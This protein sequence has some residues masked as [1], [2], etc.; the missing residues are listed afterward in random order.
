MTPR[1]PPRKGT[2]Y[3]V[4]PP[5]SDSLRMWAMTITGITLLVVGLI[6]LIDVTFDVFTRNTNRPFE[7]V[8]F[9]FTAGVAFMWFGTGRKFGHHDVDVSY[10]TTKGDDSGE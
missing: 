6:L 1:R 3:Y 9:L 4:I 10:K 5:P 2:D 7:E 8:A